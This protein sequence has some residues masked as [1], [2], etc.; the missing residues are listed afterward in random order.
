MRATTV[1]TRLTV[2]A[3]ICLVSA[4]TAQTTRSNT[5]ESLRSAYDAATVRITGDVQRQQDDARAQ[6]GKALETALMSLKLKA[7]IDGYA[8]AD[9]ETKRFQE[10]KTVPAI[11]PH[12]CLAAAIDAYKKQI[13]AVDVDARRRK[14]TLMKQYIAALTTLIRD[15][16]VQDKLVEAKAVGDVRHAAEFMLAELDVETQA[17]KAATADRPP[18]RVVTE[19]KHKPDVQQS[20]RLASN[21]EQP[22][23]VLQ[24]VKLPAV[25]PPRAT[26]PEAKPLVVEQAHPATQDGK[27]LTVDLGGGVQLDLVWI[28]AGEF[29][30]GSPAA[31]DRYGKLPQHHVRLSKGFW[32]GKYEVTQ[33]QWQLVMGTN[34]SQFKSPR[35]PVENVSWDD[36]QDFVSKLNS[37][38]EIRSAQGQVRLPTEA[39][40]EYACRAGSTTEEIADFEQMGWHAANSGKASHP[41]GQKRAN[42]WGLYDM[43]GNVREW[44]QDWEGAYDTGAA[45]DPAGPASGSRRV[46]RG[47][48]WQRGSGMC[49]SVSRDFSAPAFKD[50]STGF[51]VVCSR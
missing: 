33:E 37:R 23:P 41:V 10:E 20:A 47:G 8:V 25:E 30:M 6:Y 21:V 26:A 13:L 1:I 24:E 22:R 19:E 36:C 4:A 45:T 51:R 16:M 34:P 15:E 29:E 12:A 9:Q 7:D 35:N 43:H 40:W 27:T 11:A 31:E 14:T 42:A 28:P 38:A 48:S 18:E 46:V 2:L 32:I 50:S 5:L 49:K 39:E 44:C 17:P 3:C